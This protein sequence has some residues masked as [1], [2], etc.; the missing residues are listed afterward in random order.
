MQLR[1]A[2]Q[3]RTQR[4]DAAAQLL[5]IDTG[6]WRRVLGA[7]AASGQA[8]CIGCK[9]S[10]ASRD[11]GSA[12]HSFSKRHAE[13]Q[14][15]PGRFQ[16]AQLSSLQLRTSSMN[17]HQILS[18]AAA[19]MI[20]TGALAAAPASHATTLEK[21]FGVATAHHNDCAGISGLHSCKGQATINYDPGDFRVVPTGTCEKMG[22]LDMTQAKA[23]LKNPAK[24]KAFEA[25]ME[26]KAKG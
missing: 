16:P 24:I 19:T 6:P 12:V 18:I 14:R 8:I 20:A 22:G 21:C 23:I 17:K 2:R 26:E 4:C 9:E 5:R 1:Q 3:D 10:G 13:P 25:K 7:C 11:Q 15:S